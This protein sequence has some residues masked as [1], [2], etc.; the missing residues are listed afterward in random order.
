MLEGVNRGD[1][2]PRINNQTASHQVVELRKCVSNDLLHIII[3]AKTRSQRQRVADMFTLGMV[4]HIQPHE[5]ALVEKPPSG[6]RGPLD[7]PERDGS[8]NP[9]DQREMQQVVML[10]L[11]SPRQKN[12]L[13]QHVADEQL[14]SD[15]AHAPEVRQLVP[16]FSE[17]NLR[18]AVLAR[19]DDAMAPFRGVGGAAVVDERH[20][21]TIREINALVAMVRPL[22]GRRNG[23]THFVRPRG[24]RRERS[25]ASGPCA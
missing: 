6:V 16:A 18:R 15:A 3:P 5:P 23:E 24:R 7:E 19:V 17:Q 11:T 9:L 25:R 22:C 8:D 12:R 10:P 1:P 13:K 4:K 20:V 14:E 2:F 21:A